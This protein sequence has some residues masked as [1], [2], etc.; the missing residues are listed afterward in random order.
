M[1]EETDERQPVLSAFSA[2]VLR[3]AL[4]DIVSKALL[5]AVLATA[6]LVGLLIWQGGSIPAWIAVAIVAAA[7]A[8]AFISRRRLTTL[9]RG[10]GWR[11]ARIAELEPLV[12]RTEQLEATVTAYDYGLSRHE[13]YGAHIAE[14]LDHLQR[15]V[16][17]DIDVGIEEYVVRGILEPARDVIIEDPAEDVRLSVLLPSEEGDGCFVMAWAAGHNLRS[18]NKY[19]Q[20]ISKTLA[21]LAYEEDKVY[22]WDDVTE[23]DRYEA[24][25]QATRPLHS[26]ISIPLRCG[27]AVVGVFNCV[28]SEPNVF[29]AAE[30]SY[31]TSLGSVLSVAVNIWLGQEAQEG[32][33]R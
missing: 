32:P 7:V 10:L 8:V 30:R 9:Q 19:R 21:R 16:V 26:M 28:A 4:V 2:D 22:C 33:E 14:V 20:P 6:A 12:E 31:V 24:N 29:D 15:V 27:D 18:Q 17:G 1:G 13:L 3:A 25:P 11:D 23:D 5:G